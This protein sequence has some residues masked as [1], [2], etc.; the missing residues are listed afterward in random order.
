[1][2]SL[3]EQPADPLGDDLGGCFDRAWYAQRYPDVAAA[4][5]DP[6][7]HYLNHGVAENRDPNPLFDASWYLEQNP[8]VAAS[9]L[10]P[11]LHYFEFGAAELRNP[12]P[13]FDA[14]YYV[15]EHPEAAGNPLLSIC[16]S[17]RHAAS[18]PR[19]S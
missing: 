5:I 4:G 13:R 17:G 10:N 9:Q 1:M 18:R 14:T 7:H 16:A 12:H 6:L 11:L 19:R 2:Q 15:T 3:R 8:D